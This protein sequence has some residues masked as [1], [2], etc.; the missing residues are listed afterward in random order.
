MIQSAIDITG[1]IVLFYLYF[2]TAFEL[3]PIVECCFDLLKSNALLILI[4]LFIH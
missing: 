4:F 2:F 1:D 3:R